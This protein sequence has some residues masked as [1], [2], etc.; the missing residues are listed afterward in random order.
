MK[1]IKKYSAR[2]GKPAQKSSYVDGWQ[3][4]GETTSDSRRGSLVRKAAIGAAAILAPVAALAVTGNL[5][6]A[7]K[8][9]GKSKLTADE[10]AVCEVGPGTQEITF[11]AGGGR[12]VAI[13]A[14][15]GSGHGEGD[16]CW[17]E[18]ADAVDVAL[19]GEEPL[20]GQTII[21]PKEVHKVAV[22]E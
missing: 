4:A 21:I 11:K 13:L 3:R 10:K 2:T 6:N 8:A 5:S 18:A 17:S 22:N 16:P 12:N 15:K 14:I 7:P 19:H 1:P 9:E 20:A